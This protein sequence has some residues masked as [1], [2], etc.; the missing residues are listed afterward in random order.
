M[1]TPFSRMHWA[2]FSMASSRSRSVS[3]SPDAA[4]EDAPAASGSASSSPES[5]SEP[6][7][8]DRPSSRVTAMAA[9]SR[10]RAVPLFLVPVL[11]MPVFW[12]VVMPPLQRTQRSDS[13]GEL[14]TFTAFPYRD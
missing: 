12:M 13:V 4:E 7:A 8:A 11:W 1:S 9:R 10:R 14:S 6:H 5:E 2:N 3:S